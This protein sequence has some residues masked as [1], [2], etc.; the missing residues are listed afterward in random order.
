MLD[1]KKVK[2]GSI[3]ADL[4]ISVPFEELFVPE[5]EE[6]FPMRAAF[7]R[8]IE[9]FAEPKFPDI[10]GLEVPFSPLGPDSTPAKRHEY[11]TLDRLIKYGGTPG[12]KACEGDSVTCSPVCKVRF[13][14]LIRADKTAESRSKSLPPTPVSL[15]PTPAPA[16][17]P[18]TPGPSAEPKASARDAD[19]DHLSDYAPSDDGAGIGAVAS[20]DLFVPDTAFLA[21]DRQFRRSNPNNNNQIV[22][23]CC[24]DDSEIGLASVLFGVDCLR[25]GMSTLDLANAAHVE[26]AKGQVK[27]GSPIWLSIPCTEHTPWQRMNIHRHGPAYKDRLKKRQARIRRMIRLAI[28]LAEERLQE[29][30]HV[31]AE[32]PRDSLLWQNPE[33]LAF[34]ARANLRRVHFHGCALGV[35]GQRS[36]IKK[37]W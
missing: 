6:V 14:G 5:G 36:P 15:P 19:S 4:A 34:E 21:R 33:W 1:Y 8:A 23:Y 9:G 17:A 18:P 13:D 10:K 11:I 7:E 20:P 22:E 32:W 12:C 35:R 2:A 3:G 29:G 24:D 16:V 37:P 31:S 28:D 30:S 26:Q 27:P 25:L